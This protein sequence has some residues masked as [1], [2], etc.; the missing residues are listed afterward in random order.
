MEWETGTKMVSNWDYATDLMPQSSSSKLE[1]TLGAISDIR[2]NQINPIVGLTDQSL[3]PTQPPA[4]SRRSRD[5]EVF[6][7]VEGCKADLSKCRDY[8]RKHKVCEVHSK[9]PVVMVGGKEQRFCQQCSRF[10]LLV[11]FDEVKRSCRKRLAGH[12]RRRRKPPQ[13]DP[14]SPGGIFLNQH[15]A[16]M[17]SYPQMYTSPNITQ[18]STK[19]NSMQ[20]GH[21]SSIRNSLF[22]QASVNLGALQVTHENL[23]T[24]S[25]WQGAPESTCALSLLS[26]TTSVAIS[27]GQPLSPQLN[28]HEN[29]FRAGLNTMHS[30]E[31]VSLAGFRYCNGLCP[32]PVGE[33]SEN[34]S[35]HSLPFSWQ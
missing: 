18:E 8:H 19:W 10:Q 16:R 5:R 7:L 6:C 22:S 26:S 20:N 27:M 3:H 23:H 31:N 30:S 13:P 35:A 2:S 34:G 14:L 11:E 21:N 9:T 4:L 29:E 15:G 12:N 25:T 33:G 28:F 1:L 17:S 24:G 32:Y